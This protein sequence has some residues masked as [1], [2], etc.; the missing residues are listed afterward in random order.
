MSFLV[1]LITSGQLK[2]QLFTC[3]QISKASPNEST[4]IPHR[5]APEKKSLISRYCK[6]KMMPESLVKCIETLFP[7]E[8]EQIHFS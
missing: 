4:V 5:S 7:H 1:H 6:T 8:T 2:A 3:E